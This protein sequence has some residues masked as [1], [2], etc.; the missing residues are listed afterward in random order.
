MYDSSRE[1][2]CCNKG[3]QIKTHSGSRWA[4][5]YKWENNSGEAITTTSCG[6]RNNGRGGNVSKRKDGSQ[7]EEWVGERQ[8]ADKNKQRRTWLKTWE[9]NGRNFRMEL[10]SFF[11]A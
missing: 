4:I 10:E 3:K 6:R 2:H 5:F 9:N 7:Q 1:K 8:R 11:G